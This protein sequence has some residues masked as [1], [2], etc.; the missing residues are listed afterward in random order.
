M[1]PRN[2]DQIAVLKGSFYTHVTNIVQLGIKASKV[3]CVVSLQCVYTQL[4]RIVSS[5][6]GLIS[7]P[8]LYTM[9]Q[10]AVIQL[11]EI[12][13]VNDDCTEASVHPCAL[14]LA[15]TKEVHF[16]RLLRPN[17]YTRI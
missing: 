1:R 6:F 16:D 14:R 5:I 13:I 9:Q 12:E 17:N 2:E 11:K 15:E 7:I 3:Y 4:F 10:P 8:A